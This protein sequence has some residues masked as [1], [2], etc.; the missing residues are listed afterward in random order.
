M[1][2]GVAMP[3]EGRGVDDAPWLRCLS[4]RALL[5]ILVFIGRVV[6]FGPVMMATRSAGTSGD[7]AL[8]GLEDA[9]ERELR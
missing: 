6:V 3:H 4:C 9:T 2:E 5:A 1:N 8:L 7:F